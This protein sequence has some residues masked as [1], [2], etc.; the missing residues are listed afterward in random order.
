MEL[1]PVAVGALKPEVAPFTWTNAP[2]VTLIPAVDVTPATTNCC[3]PA[4]HV[5]LADPAKEPVE[6]YWT[7]VSAPPGEPDPPPSETQPPPS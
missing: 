7:L 3:D 4:F 1:Y 2:P 5:K 6:L